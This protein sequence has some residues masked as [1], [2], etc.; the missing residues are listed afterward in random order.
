LLSIEQ[1]WFE[2]YAPN[3]AEWVQTLESCL[4]DFDSS[5]HFE[6]VFI[7]DKQK[8]LGFREGYSLPTEAV[9]E[10]VD[11]PVLPARAREASFVPEDFQGRSAI[12]CRLRLG[13]RVVAQCRSNGFAVGDEFMI[14]VETFG[15]DDRGKGYATA[16]GVALLDHCLKNG[17]VP[18]WETTEDNTASRRLAIKLGFVEDETYPVYAIEF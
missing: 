2:I 17:L 8:Y 9:I 7:W 5:R 1:N 6:S 10:Q 18:L 14:D 3:T 15:D 11:V 13:D 4:G 12:G 16:A